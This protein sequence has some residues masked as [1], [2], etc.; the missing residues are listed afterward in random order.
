MS[1]EDLRLAL[2]DAGLE[3]DIPHIRRAMRLLCELG[4]AQHVS[5]DGVGLYEHLHLDNHHDHLVCVRCGRILEFMEVTI[6]SAQEDVCRRHGFVP[7]MHKLE[8]R[9]VCSDCAE[10]MPPTRSLASCLAGERVEIAEVLGGRGIRQRLTDMG[11][12]R[13]TPVTVLTSEGPVT[14]D[15][16]GGRLAVGRNEATRIIVRKIAG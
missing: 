2:A 13:G 9:G 11:L 3:I 14:L 12:T 4:V 7:L 15:V 8:I 6:E 16:R 10:S 5:L 1:C